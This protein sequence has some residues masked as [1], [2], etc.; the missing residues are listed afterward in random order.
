[1]YLVLRELLRGNECHAHGSEKL[2]PKGASVCGDPPVGWAD[3]R[4]LCT[5]SGLAGVWLGGQSWL[6]AARE[7]TVMFVGP[8]HTVRSVIACVGVSRYVAEPR[9]SA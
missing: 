8:P 7:R 5:L 4:L 1:V 2:S 9:G 6:C 3:V